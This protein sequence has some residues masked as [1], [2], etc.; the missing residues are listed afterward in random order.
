M[1][2]FGWLLSLSLLAGCADL[3]CGP[4]GPHARPDLVAQMFM[5]RHFPGGEVSDADWAGFAAN[6]ITPRF[7]DGFTVLDGSG[8][9]R[10]VDGVVRETTK[11]LWVAAPDTDSVRQALNDIAA[12]YRE[13]FHQQSV[14]LVVT[15][16]CAAF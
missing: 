8:Q 1:I 3:A 9:W 7:P 10:G 13:Q 11:I 5:G 15:H 2:R 16:G 6:V 12:A 4:F 14:G